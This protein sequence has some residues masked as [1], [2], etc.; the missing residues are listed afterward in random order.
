M[1]K[2][3]FSDPH[4]FS[5][6]II[7]NCRRPFSSISEM[8]KTIIHRYNEVISK[9][10]RCYWLGDVMYGATKDKVRAILSQMH[11]RKDL[12]LGNHD[13]N[14]SATWW[15]DAGFD[16]VFEH[17]IYLAE[18]YIMLS[19]EPLLEF[20]YTTPTVNIHGHTHNI[21]LPYQ[22]FINVCVEQTNYR[23]VP[24]CNPFLIKKREFER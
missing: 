12:I 21:N 22:N 11:G 19:H 14:H 2:F 3:V 1:P 4:F 8:N 9:H 15:R 10:D 23:P 16:T 18:E 17:P 20:R 6:R 5:E 7:I 24:L 13:R